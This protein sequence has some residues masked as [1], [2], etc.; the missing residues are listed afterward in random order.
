MNTK[1][2]KPLRC[3]LLLRKSTNQQETTRQRNELIAVAEEKG[4]VIVSII[5]EAVSGSSSKEERLA[6]KKVEGMVVCDEPEI[7]LV[8]CW[9]VSRIARVNSICHEFLELLTKNN[10]NLYWHTQRM[11]TLLDSIDGQPRRLN[12]VAALLFAFLAEQSRSEL[13]TM[14]L[15]LVSGIKAYREK[16]N[17]AWGRKKGSSMSGEELITRHAD[18]VR[19]LKKGFSV[20]NTSAITKKGVSTVQR[21]RKILKEEGFLTA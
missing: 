7:D 5:E 4:Y 15:R 6:L 19:N 2:T 1:N 10:I 17:G 21:V 18:I 14:K 3:C 16:N 13:E 8:L 11:F 9:E 20:R 12:P